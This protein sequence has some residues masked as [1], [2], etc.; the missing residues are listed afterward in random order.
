MLTG[1]QILCENNMESTDQRVNVLLV[2]GDANDARLLMMGL[3][4]AAPG[5]FDVVHADRMGT[6]LEHVGSQ[7]FDVILLDLSLPDGNGLPI[8]LKAAQSGY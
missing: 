1:V 4:R 5:R 8:F 2:E 6:A 7:S 3:T